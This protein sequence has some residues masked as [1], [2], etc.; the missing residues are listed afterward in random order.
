VRTRARA[1]KRAKDVSGLSAR[2]TDQQ[3][4]AA[5]RE[6]GR[7]LERPNLNWTVR[8]RSSLI[9]VESSD[10]RWTHEIRWQAQVGVAG[11]SATTSPTPR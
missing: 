1:N 2:R 5:E 4:P 3:G 10:L 7:A 11:L 6:R 9:E 8:I